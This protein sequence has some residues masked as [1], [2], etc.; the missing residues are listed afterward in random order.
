LFGVI[1]DDIPKQQRDLIS[2]NCKE[3][4]MKKTLRLS[5]IT[6]GVLAASVLL[7]S[8]AFAANYKGEGGY[9]DQGSFKDQ[10]PCPQIPTLMSGFY[11]G[12]QLGYDSYR[13]RENFAAGGFT[14]N[15]VMNATGFV[16]GLFAGYGQYFSDYYYLGGE[17]LGNY[18]GASTSWT[19]NDGLGDSVTSK[20]NAYGTWGL[21]A[22]PGLKLNNESL[23]YLRLGW[24][25]TRLKASA[26]ASG[27]N[28]GSASASQSNW[29]NGFVYG[30]GLESLITGNWSVRTEYTHTNL[31]SFSSSNLSTSF[32]PSNNQFMLG[33]VY[34]FA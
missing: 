2:V 6:A 21:A 19:A 13:V 30:L 12:G 33:L 16:G 5:A 4:C 7:T 20:F 22:L 15:P 26:S 24:N 9:K 10:A 25:W 11:L 8:N 27:P 29:S 28:V 17:V 32:N 1:R 23:L 14:A 34:H 18:S 3:T 31:S